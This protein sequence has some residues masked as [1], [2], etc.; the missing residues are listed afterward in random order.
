MSKIKVPSLMIVGAVL[1]G[2]VLGSVLSGQ[3]HAESK[4]LLS[5]LH[6]FNQ[7]LRYIKSNY[8]EEVES[9]ELVQSAIRGM[10]EQLDPHSTYVDAESF[11]RMNER[12]TG[13]YEGIGISFE[14]RDG[15]ITVI[16]AI[17]GGPSANLGIRAGDRIVKIEGES[18]KD[19]QS[20]DV[21]AKLKGAKGSKVN[22][23]IA[24]PG[25]EKELP[26]TITRDKI[27][28]YSVPYAFMLDDGKT[29]YVR[30][31]RFSATTS[32]ELEAA[33]RDLEQTGMERLVL[34]LRNNSGGFL[35]QAIEVADRFINGNEVIVY[36]KGRIDGSSQYY[37][38]TS[39]MTHEGFPLIVLVNHGSASASEIVAGAVQDHDRGV[40]AG[41]STFGKGLVQ[42]QYMLSNGAALLLTVARYYTPSGRLIQRSYED[43]DEYLDHFRR[44]LEDG[45]AEVA[46]ADTTDRPIFYTLNEK[47][48]VY[49]GGG[50]MPDVTIESEFD[51]TETQIKL[52]QSRLFFE[53]A[54]ELATEEFPDVQ[55]VSTDW[56][57]ADYDVPDSAIKQF[58]E[59]AEDSEVVELTK[60]ELNEEKDYIRSGIKRELAGTMWGAEARYRVIIVD[61]PQ[62]AEALTHFPEAMEMAKIYEQSTTT[63]R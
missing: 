7:V 35:N 14:I 9:Q 4:G 3:V 11:N 45:E 21:V 48:V 16:S 32:E 39:E 25:L 28:I 51:P 22:I 31:I 30:M 62:L 5:Q 44:Q 26:F 59:I 17:E 18:A 57:L 52:E 12:N 2:F 40:V 55:A 1:V 37:Y 53:F 61:D 60:D 6:V 34:D 8:V 23:H 47:R 19:L 46:E 36:T 50:I 15:Y 58:I 42:R 49:G 33:L 54:A 29:G 10:L 20:Q 56:F 24:R 63:H 27:P 43:R 38:S 41:V 13:E